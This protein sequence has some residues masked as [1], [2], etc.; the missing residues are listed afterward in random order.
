MPDWR[1]LLRALARGAQQSGW[2]GPLIIDE[3]PY[4][5]ASNEALP[6]IVQGFLDHEARS[7][8]LCVVLAG[9]SQHMMQGLQLDR[10]SPLFGRATEA[11]NLQPLPAGYIAEALDKPTPVDS[12]R[13]WTVWGGIPRYWELAEPFGNDTDAAIHAL[14][15][16]PSGPLHLEPDRLLVEELPS[17]AA[18]RPLLD[19][20]GS[21]AH[22]L[23]EIAG[24]LGGTATSLARPLMRLQELGLLDREL[25]F[26]EPERGGKRSLYKI[27]DPFMRMWFRV[28]APNRAALAAGTA[29]ARAAMWKRQRERLYAEAW[30]D[31]C[32]AA[33]PRLAPSATMQDEAWGP[34]RRYW[35]G[36]GPEWDVVAAPMDGD[37]L[38]LG[39]VKWSDRPMTDGEVDRI[40]QD[41]IAKEI[42]QERWASGRK[43]VHV[44]FVPE[45]QQPRRRMG[46]RPFR[47]VT[48]RDV[49]AAL[50]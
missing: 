25:P 6:S 23:S 8:A 7:A 30:E 20:A 19:A 40:G 31:L 2:R 29:A 50:R 5:V 33:V 35:K 34:A 15:L 13:A 14:V 11:L 39:E 32:R 9:S 3:F 18:L 38:L 26:G 37:A 44:V 4:L 10:S 36:D 45:M 17:A 41:L 48:A 49:L 27:G 12:L 43:P 21:G 46:A 42:P 16:D 47:I 28:V 22:R 24:R 1:S